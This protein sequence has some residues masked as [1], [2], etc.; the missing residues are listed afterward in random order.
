MN[1]PEKKLNILSLQYHCYPDE[2]GGAWGFTSE[3][4]KRFVA[5]GQ[6]VHLITCKAIASL[7]YDEDIDGGSFP[8]TSI[9]DSKGV[10]LLST[11]DCAA[12]SSR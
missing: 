8:L 11:S 1:G 5:R 3:V 10:C 7:P 2:V 12:D 4:N 9:K 6:K